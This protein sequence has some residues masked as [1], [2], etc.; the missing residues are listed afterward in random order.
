[1]AARLNV[2]V[3]ML[4]PRE[5]PPR[6]N[7]HSDAFLA[8]IKGLAQHYRL[9]FTFSICRLLWRTLQWRDSNA[10]SGARIGGHLPASMSVP[11]RLSNFHN[12]NDGADMLSES[13]PKFNGWNE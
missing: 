11:S 13:S 5:T 2:I 7:G 12:W 3:V 8:G 10:G 6:T 1:M 9:L 4:G